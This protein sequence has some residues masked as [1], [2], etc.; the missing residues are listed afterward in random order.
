ML[1]LTFHSGV[2]ICIF[3]GVML[4]TLTIAVINSELALTNMEY[5]VMKMLARVPSPAFSQ[6]IPA[7]EHWTLQLKKASARSIVLWWRHKKHV[8]RL[9]MAG[10]KV[11]KSGAENCDPWRLT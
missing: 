2:A 3:F 11:P 4:V 5:R 8:H 7:Q 6:L 1:V 10:M 9:E